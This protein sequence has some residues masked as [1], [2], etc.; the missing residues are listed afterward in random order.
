MVKKNLQR[1]EEDMESFVFLAV[2][3]CIVYRLFWS[4]DRQCGKSDQKVCDQLPGEKVNDD[5]A[6]GS[7]GAFFLLEEFIDP[8]VDEQQSTTQGLVQNEQFE[9]GYFEDEFLD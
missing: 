9:D 1:Q 6:G 3:I 5:F 2:V 8:S 7:V 4:K